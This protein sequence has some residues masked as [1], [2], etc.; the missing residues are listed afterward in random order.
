MTLPSA[1]EILLPTL[2]PLVAGYAVARWLGFSTKPLMILLRYVLFPVLLFTGLQERMPFYVF[3]LVAATGSVMTLVGLVLARHAHRFLKPHV[4]SSAAVINIA[5]F[6]APV[7]ALSW[8]ADGLGSACAL[9]VGAAL[10]WSF[11]ELGRDW[12]ALLREPWVYATAT[13]LLFQ[14]GQ[15]SAPWLDSMVTPL[16]LASYPVLLLFLGASMHPWVSMRDGSAWATVCV[17]MLSGLCVGIIAVAVLP[18]SAAVAEGVI[19]VSLA[20]P[21]TRAM[22]L[23][24]SIEDSA[25]SR[26]A[27]TL[28]ACVSLL[29]MVVLLLTGWKPWA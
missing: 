18:F 23:G 27:A 2:A 1:F 28:G 4:D 10:T 9:F 24:P 16:A 6:A 11:L 12:Q 26:A 29:A 17:R 19:L 5:C 8:A 14:A 20:P 22:T 3:L 15:I 13:A 21:A 25:R 7:L